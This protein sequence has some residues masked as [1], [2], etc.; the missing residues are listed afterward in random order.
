MKRIAGTDLVNLKDGRKGETKNRKQNTKTVD[1]QPS[2]E[3]LLQTGM[4]ETLN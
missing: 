3:K 4:D 2:M 1:L